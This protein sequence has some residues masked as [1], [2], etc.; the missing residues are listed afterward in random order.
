M[1]PKSCLVRLGPLISTCGVPLPHL[2]GAR[3]TCSAASVTCSTGRR[4]DRACAA[5]APCSPARARCQCGGRA[6]QT[7]DPMHEQRRAARARRWPRRAAPGCRASG[8]RDDRAQQEIEQDREDDRKDERLGEVQRVEDR[9][10]EQ[11][12]QGDVARVGVLAEQARQLA[13][14]GLATGRCGLRVE[15]LPGDVGRENGPVVRLERRR[16]GPLVMD[17]R[18]GSSPLSRPASPR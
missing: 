13:G 8:A 18:G 5:T 7:I 17:A 10:D 15:R 1:P 6:R 11:A 16:L 9:E 14:V 12:D 4:S 3:S 2:G